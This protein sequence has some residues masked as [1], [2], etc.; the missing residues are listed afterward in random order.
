MPKATSSSSDYHQSARIPAMPLVTK[1]I[2]QVKACMKEYLYKGV[3]APELQP[4]LD[5]VTFRT[6][7]MIRPGLV[8]LA[9]KAC[10]AIQADHIKAGAILE[11]IHYATLLH[12]DVI[13][14]SHKRRAQAT[15]N[16][17]W[18]NESAVLLGDFILTVVFQM[19]TELPSNAA[20]VVADTTA[21]VCQGEL[22][23]TLTCN[24]WHLSVSH[25]LEIISDKSASFFSG[26]CRVGSLLAGADEQ[27][28]ES[29]A[30]YGLN[31]G[32]AFQIADDLLDIWGD[33]NQT[34]KSS[35]RDLDNQKPTLPLI[36]LM[37]QLTEAE[38]ETL[39]DTLESPAD[40][41]DSLRAQL[42]ESGSL[43]HAREMSE[44]YVA[45]AISAL[46]P[47]ADTPIGEKLIALARFLGQREV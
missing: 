8:L 4:L 37:E 7:K 46:G 16:S 35:G 25:Y 27:A 21:Q 47:I 30:S 14:H 17:L 15:A 24:D 29:L 28:T 45:Q 33:H 9:G 43:E 19:C 41:T 23:Q 42:V 6:G 32:I 31:V 5:H 34:G 36:H 11:M 2:D 1:E 44:M 22:R 20:K 40:N 12:D 39:I 38:Q 18:G 10:G 13:D 26:C 3:R